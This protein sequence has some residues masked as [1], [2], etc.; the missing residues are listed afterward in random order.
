[1]ERRSDMYQIADLID[2][3]SLANVATWLIEYDKIVRSSK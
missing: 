2:E 1:M 3:R